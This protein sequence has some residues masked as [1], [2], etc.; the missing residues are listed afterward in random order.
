[1]RKGTALIKNVKGGLLVG[2]KEI[3]S[4]KGP[5]TGSFV[6]MICEISASRLN[7]LIINIQTSRRKLKVNG[8]ERHYE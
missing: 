4:K 3:E 2:N 8:G 5:F 7:L 1:M 6:S